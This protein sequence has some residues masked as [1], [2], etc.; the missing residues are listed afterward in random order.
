M[1]ASVGV[2]VAPAAAA[3]PGV[4]A[5][6]ITIGLITSLTGEAAP[7]YTDN[8]S[9]GPGQSGPAER[10]GWGWMGRKIRLIVEDDATNPATN[11][12][13]SQS[14]V[15]KGVFGMVDE[16]P[17]V[18]GGAKVLQQAGTPVTDQAGLERMVDGW[19]AEHPGVRFSSVVLGPIR[20]R[21]EAPGTFAANWD[22][23]KAAR[24]IH[25]WTSLGPIDD[26][27]IDSGGF[28]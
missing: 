1:V 18:F 28:V 13:A 22:M 19:P 21:N 2:G 23:D 15:S 4:T 9:G 25:K 8:T 14:L 6:T 10:T 12:T 27:T 26:Q 11:Q 20:S 16:S 3:T 7:Q 5:K 24:S 17:V